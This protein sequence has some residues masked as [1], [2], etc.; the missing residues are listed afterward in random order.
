M[1]KSI[2]YLSLLLLAMVLP[3]GC[4]SDEENEIQPVDENANKT[5]PIAE[6]KL[7]PGI[8]SFFNETLPKMSYYSIE[9]FFMLEDKETDVYYLINNEQEFQKVYQGHLALPKID[10]KKYTLI[11][12]RLYNGGVTVYQQYLTKGFLR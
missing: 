2:Y 4:S 7:D 3:T 11:I 6:D 8:V 1:R 9:D 5:F 12:G 10:F